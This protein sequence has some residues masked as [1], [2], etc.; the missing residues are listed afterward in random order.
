MARALFWLIAIALG[1]EFWVAYVPTRFNDAEWNRLEINGA[2]RTSGWTNYDVLGTQSQAAPL[3]KHFF[4]IDIKNQSDRIV[5]KVQV[6]LTLKTKP[7]GRVLF[8][9]P[10]Q[11]CLRQGGLNIW[12]GSNGDCGFP[13]PATV[14]DFLET[15]GEEELANFYVTVE[16]TAKP[17]RLI[18]LIVDQ[19]TSATT[20][21]KSLFE[22]AQAPGSS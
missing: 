9:A 4:V 16:G 18:A 7:D 6:Y 15:G 13:L 12:P 3:A 22:P 20:S 1:Y 2:V 21:L 10:H 8:D 14:S 17:I 5:R 19:I 11:N